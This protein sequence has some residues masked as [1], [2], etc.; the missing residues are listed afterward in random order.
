MLVIF[1]AL[2][3]AAEP[4]G[5][6]LP[7]PAAKWTVWYDRNALRDARV[8]GHDVV[9]LTAA[10]TLLRFDAETFALKG[11]RVDVAVSCLGR[12]SGELLAG[13]RGAVLRVDPSTLATETL[14]KV[15]GTPT[16]IG[17]SPSGLVVVTDG[18]RRTVV[19]SDREFSTDARGY[20]FLADKSGGLWVGF[21]H[22]E[23]GGVTSRIELATGT[24]EVMLEDPSSGVYGFIEG[25]DRVWAF[26]GM[27]HFDIAEPMF[28]PAGKVGVPP[29]GPRGPISQAVRVGDRMLAFSWGQLWRTDGKHWRRA[30]GIRL[31]YPGGRPYAV[32]YASAIVHVESLANGELVLATALD[33]L[34]TLK[35]HKARRHTLDSGWHETGMIRRIDPN[36]PVLFGEVASRWSGSGW[37]IVDISRKDGASDLTPRTIVPSSDG[38]FFVI[39]F[40]WTDR[41]S[42]WRWKDGAL[43]LLAGGTGDESQSGW[44]SHDGELWYEWD[45]AVYRL[46]SD[47]MERTGFSPPGDLFDLRS[48]GGPYLVGWEHGRPAESASRVFKLEDGSLTAIASFVADAA[49]DADGRLV[50]LDGQ[51]AWIYDSV[52]KERVPARFTPPPGATKIAR[53]GSGRL[54]LAGS[55]VWTVFPDGVRSAEIPAF[56]GAEIIGLVADPSHPDGILAATRFSIVG[57][58][59]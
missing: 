12:S 16:W 27:E 57:V 21:D 33:G 54:W 59:R 23:W 2:T 3:L 31:R 32:G 5:P 14:R 51:G 9:A 1:V 47:G 40:D 37:C 45:G 36:G 49:M 28:A 39:D 56:R 43:T 29:R 52:R 22:G 53:D 46:G 8:V 17:D 4:G 20:S 26:G 48:I 18:E 55:D 24:T 35:R 6:S 38:S 41:R 50:V 15:S 10:G 42:I 58:R 25:P 11:E 13:T 7:V 44:F 30:G 34:A 19:T